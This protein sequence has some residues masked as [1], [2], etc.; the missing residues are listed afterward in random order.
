M[1]FGGYDTSRFIPNSANFN[2]A[3]DIDRDI[4]VAVQSIVYSG[5]T[6]ANLLPT[7]IYAFIES[8]DPNFWLP[9]EA[10]EASFVHINQHV[11]PESARV[12][13]LV[14]RA[15]AASHRRADSQHSHRLRLVSPFPEALMNLI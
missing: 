6:Q 14:G 2:L 9:Q 13:S 10:C 4:V 3:S 12:S 8:T 11:Q 5:A 15:M 1:I 7:P